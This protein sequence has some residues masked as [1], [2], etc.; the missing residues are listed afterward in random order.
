MKK[1]K[2][3]KINWKKTISV[4][5][6]STIITTLSGCCLDNHEEV[7]ENQNNTISSLE[8]EKTN[9]EQ[10]KAKLEQQKAN[11]QEQLNKLT[12]TPEP[13]VTPESTATPEPEVVN[14]ENS[15]SDNLNDLSTDA[16]IHLFYE[17]GVLKV[18]SIEEPYYLKYY[19]KTNGGPDAGEAGRG[20]VQEIVKNGKK[21][22]VDANDFSKV[23]LSDYDKI[24]TPYYLKYY[25]KTNG[26]PD[27]GEAGRGYVQ[28]IVKNGKKY[29]VD[30]NDFSKVLLS[31]YDKIGT[32]YY[33]K[34]YS[35]TNG[36]PDAGEAGRGY[37]QEIVKNGKA[38]LVDANDFSIVLA[39][40]YKSISQNDLNTTIVFADGHTEVYV[41]KDFK[42]SK[43][44]VLTQ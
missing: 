39:S 31:D 15:N 27:A 16:A 22:L 20:Y 14:E 38:Y 40:D 43:S 13:T 17:N 6:T 44:Y 37:V 11:L 1:I 32:P 35:K 4:L 25:S 30:A 24:G 34:Y 3:L 7:I 42:T 36:G 26:G 41:N 19:S 10:Q 21:Y 33:L 23:L 29:L 9:L 5:L 2:N 28:E 8:Q 18:D 12:A